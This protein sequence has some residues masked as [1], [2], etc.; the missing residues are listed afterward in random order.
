[1]KYCA[2][3]MDEDSMNMRGELEHSEVSGKDRKQESKIHTAGASLK[4]FG[5]VDS[6]DNFNFGQRKITPLRSAK[7]SNHTSKDVQSGTQKRGSNDLDLDNESKM[8]GDFPEQTNL[9]GLIRAKK[10]RIS[11]SLTQETKNSG[12]IFRIKRTRKV[13]PCKK[14]GCP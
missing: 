6:L 13:C 4:L 12:E 2:Q 14:Q 1:M 11:E 9:T 8:A 7:Q 5:R 10:R 3:L